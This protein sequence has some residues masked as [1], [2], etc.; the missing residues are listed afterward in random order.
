MTLGVGFPSYVVMVGIR[1]STGKD[2]CWISR[3]KGE[4]VVNGVASE[5]LAANLSSIFLSSLISS[6]TRENVGTSFFFDDADIRLASRWACKSSSAFWLVG[7]T[8]CMTTSVLLQFALSL[9]ILV[10]LRTSVG[11][12]I[13][14]RCKVWMVQPWCVSIC[15]EVRLNR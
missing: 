14:F 4:L 15:C 3:L 9:V 13:P 2:A 10:M 8:H 11:R 1:N 5:L 7:R 12:L 6:Y